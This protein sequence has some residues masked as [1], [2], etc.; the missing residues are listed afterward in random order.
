MADGFKVEVAALRDYR[1]ALEDFKTQADT[2][3]DLVDRADVGDESW[4]LVGL[5]TKGS[6]T[7]ALAELQ[8]LLDQ[9]KEGLSNTGDKFS[10]AADLYEGNDDQGSVQLGGYSVEIDKVNEVQPAGG[11]Q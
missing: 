11:G 9:M 1:N 8:G 3:T 5:A 7:D 2:F 6:Y 4:G 10:S